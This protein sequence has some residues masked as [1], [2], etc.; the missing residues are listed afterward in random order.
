MVDVKPGDDPAKIIGTVERILDDLQF[1]SG[2]SEW[3]LRCA[4][5]ALSKGQSELNEYEQRQ[6]ESHTE[7]VRKHEEAIARREK[8]RQA[9]ST[10]T[11]SE[12]Y[13]DAKDKWEEEY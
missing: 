3:D 2:V 12:E 9:L 11:Y 13:K 7:T 5:A 8:A 4:V 6:M 10:L 1:K